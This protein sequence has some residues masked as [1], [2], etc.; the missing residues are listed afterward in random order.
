MLRFG[1]SP[2][3]I[4]GWPRLRGEATI[5]TGMHFRDFL[6]MTAISLAVLTWLFFQM[7]VIVRGTGAACPKCWT[8]RTRPSLRRV[9]DF[10]FPA[11]ISPQR[12]E[13]CRTR[14]YVLKSVDYLH[15]PIARPVSR[16]LA[17]LTS[18]SEPRLF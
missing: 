11:F 8:R 15:A 7:L 9:R 16:Q 12:C 14:F 2:R 17:R 10:I 1:S 4:Y 3:T 18:L 5:V 13:S 6:V